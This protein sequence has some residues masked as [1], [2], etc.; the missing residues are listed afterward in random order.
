MRSWR[1]ENESILDQL[2][3][4][5]IKNKP[6]MNLHYGERPDSS[7]IYIDPPHC[8][9]FLVNPFRVEK[10]LRHLNGFLINGIMNSVAYI[11]KRIGEMNKSCEYLFRFPP[12]QD[13]NMLNFEC[14]IETGM[15]RAIPKSNILK[16]YVEFVQTGWQD[17]KYLDEV[18]PIDFCLNEL[19]VGDSQTF[20]LLRKMD[21]IKFLAWCDGQLSQEESENNIGLIDLLYKQGLV[22]S[23]IK[24]LR[25][26]DLKN[27]SS[28]PLSILLR[29][30]HFAL[31]YQYD[32]QDDWNW[33]VKRIKLSQETDC[34][35]DL[36]ELIVSYDFIDDK[37]IQKKQI[38]RSIHAIYCWFKDEREDFYANSLIE[39]SMLILWREAG[40]KHG[41][42]YLH[43]LIKMQCK[44]ELLY[45]LMGMIQLK[46]NKMQEAHE[47]FS[48]INSKLPKRL[49]A[50]ASYQCVWHFLTQ[51]GNN[52]STF[53]MA[54]ILWQNAKRSALANLLL[55]LLLKIDGVE[56]E[57]VQKFEQFIRLVDKEPNSI[58]CDA[59]IGDIKEVLMRLDFSFLKS[60]A[61]SPDAKQKL[62]YLLQNGCESFEN[63]E[64]YTS[65][66][67][68]IEKAE[69]LFSDDEEL[70]QLKQELQKRAD[71]EQIL[72]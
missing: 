15:G 63:D 29:S 24:K 45:Y 68:L 36:A 69:K 58:I 70:Y 38:V 60:T 19:Y 35:S 8:C 32:D 13:I 54:N 9:F 43:E 30:I 66:R 26:L 61:L 28:V 11:P 49:M 14:I 41:E 64:N 46:L 18:L 50:A 6:Q 31:L 22:G 56:D 4:F 53:Q 21:K 42:K 55:S 2:I 59:N 51:G 12:N 7:R 34:V 37:I 52:D 47:F 39:A 1:E 48:K 17:Q 33:L 27:N 71:T 16:P 65:A 62:F 72:K 44:N 25:Q 67:A 23:G 10:T 20:A 40:F 5:M 57:S 3:Q